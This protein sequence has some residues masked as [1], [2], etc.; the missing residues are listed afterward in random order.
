GRPFHPAASRL[1][2]ADPRSRWPAAADRVRAENG[3]VVREKQRQWC[4][5]RPV[6]RLL[7][8]ADLEAQPGSAA[9]GFEARLEGPV[10]ARVLAADAPARRGAAVERVRRSSPPAIARP[11]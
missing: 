4:D 10:G 1:P 6:D 11:R 3:R 8:E 9:R 7:L 5:E 2:A